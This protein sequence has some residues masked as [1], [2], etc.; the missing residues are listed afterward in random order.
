MDSNKKSRYGLALLESGRRS[1]V[2]EKR[3]K[4]IS[5]PVRRAAYPT[6]RSAIDCVPERSLLGGGGG[7]GVKE[8]YWREELC[9]AGEGPFYPQ[10]KEL[11]SGVCPESPVADF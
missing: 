11:C 1:K 2:Q 7:G 6:R 4:D 9:G 10:L 8:T 3:G 5:K